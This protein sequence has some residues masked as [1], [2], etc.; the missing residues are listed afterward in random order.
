[1]RKVIA[2]AGLACAAVASVAVAAAPASAAAVKPNLV[3]WEFINNYWNYPGGPDALTACKAQGNRDTQSGNPFTFAC[4]PTD[5]TLRNGTIES[6]Y[7]LY[8]EFLIG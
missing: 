7:A 6:G 1:M 4:D 5:R 3:Q 8:E 2:A